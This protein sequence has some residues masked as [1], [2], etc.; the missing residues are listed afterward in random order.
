M[1]IKLKLLKINEGQFNDYMSELSAGIR[2]L[3]DY[4]DMVRWNF[5]NLYYNDSEAMKELIKLN[6]KP[7]VQAAFFLAM[8]LYELRRSNIRWMLHGTGFMR[9]KSLPLR[10][11]YEIYYIATATWHA[12]DKIK[13]L[14]DELSDEAKL[15]IETI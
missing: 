8:L 5:E 9:F 1:E 4:E 11:D 12:S 10:D 7:N 6:K 14:W 15:L 13:Q 2:S 3:I